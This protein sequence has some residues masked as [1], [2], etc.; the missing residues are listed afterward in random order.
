[1]AKNRWYVASLATMS[2]KKK[3]FALPLNSNSNIDAKILIRRPSPITYLE[4]LS[5]I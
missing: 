1:M 3:H 4:L 2:M 5:K